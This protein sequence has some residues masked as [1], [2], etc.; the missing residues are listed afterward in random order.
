[1][2]VQGD[3]FQ[4][5]AGQ[6]LTAV[7]PNQGFAWPTFNDRIRVDS[8]NILGRWKHSLANGSET[9][10]QIFYDRY[11]RFDQAID[12]QNTADADF[13]YHFHLGSR[14]DI[15]SGA[16]FR[17]TGHNYQGLYDFRYD[18]SRRRDNLYSTFVQDE[19]TLTNSLALTIGSKFE[20]NAYTGFEL[21]PGA[22][23]VWTPTDRHTLWLSAAQAISQPSWFDANSQ[24]TAA[25][26]PL[27]DGGL[28]VVQIYGKPNTRAE[29]LRDYEAGYRTQVN[30]RLSLDV[31][32]FRSYYRRLQ[33]L[34]PAEPFFALTPAPPHLV[35]PSYW[36][37]RAHARTYG[38]EIFANWNVNN[39]WRLSPGFSILRMNI[40]TDPNSLDT[41]TAAT[42]G[43]SPQHQWQLRSSF[44]LAKSLDWDT[45]VYYAGQLRDGLVPS[46]TRVDSRLGWRVGEFIELSVAGQ[47]LLTPVH[48][49][50]LNAYQVHSTKI[51]RSVVGK[52]TW[53]F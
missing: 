35:L 5:R 11:N 25:T 36:D 26:F 17:F 44:R 18:P 47:N 22:Q 53:H 6:T 8:G 19:I 45:S 49:E 42:V 16:G 21:E 9:S 51:E 12:V 3:L 43:D 40:T 39:R 24:L 4:S 48:F 15:V 10:L 7:L 29:Q 46:Y 14:H 2:T 34:E 52:I 13:Q 30:K 1:M 32:A 27:Q 33:T 38:A 23:L 28:G 20:H 41:T 50:S 31:T 37:N